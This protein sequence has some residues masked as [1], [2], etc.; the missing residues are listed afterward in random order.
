[1]QQESSK[2]VIITAIFLPGALTR[3]CLAKHKMRAGSSVRNE[4]CKH[5][6]G[7]K[8]NKLIVQLTE[9]VGF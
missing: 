4:L 7:K 5:K 2:A 9:F 6:I 3:L 8:K 1:M